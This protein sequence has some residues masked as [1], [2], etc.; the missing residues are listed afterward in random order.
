MSSAAAVPQ[1]ATLVP[2]VSWF[3]RKTTDGENAANSVATT[4]IPFVIQRAL[5]IVGIALLS[6]L[7]L[8]TALAIRLESRGPAIF[9]QVRVGENGRYFRIFKFRSMYLRDDPRY[10]EPDRSQSDRDGICQKYFKDPR[11]TSVG[12]IIRKLSIDELP[13]LLNVVTGE[14]ALIGPRPALPAEV[15]EYRYGMLR[16]LDCKPGLTGLWQV[17]GRA[18]TTFDQQIE[19]DTRYVDERS[20]VMDLWILFATVP[21]VLM[22]KGAY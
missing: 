13:Q 16:R 11:I 12:R 2:T 5:A 9:T 14:M 8:L 15:N 3:T 21:A 19:L 6:P 4:G 20:P 1:S 7:M 18:D 17:S 10:Q 22:A